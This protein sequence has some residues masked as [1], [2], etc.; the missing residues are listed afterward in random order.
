LDQALKPYKISPSDKMNVINALIMAKRI[1]LGQNQ[2][3]LAQYQFVNE[4]SASLI[5]GLNEEEYMVY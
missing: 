3:G 5:K 1:V 4:A 2:K